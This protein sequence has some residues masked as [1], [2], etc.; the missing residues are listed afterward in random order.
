MRLTKTLQ[1]LI[2]RAERKGQAVKRVR[3][4]SVMGGYCYDAEYIKSTP[5]ID[6]WR[7]TITNTEQDGM[8]FKNVIVDHYGTEICHIVINHTTGERKLHNWYGQS[9]TDRDALN[10]LMD[11]YGL[12]HGFRYRPSTDKFELVS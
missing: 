4:G 9:N 12:S 5:M 11:Y 3:E 10:G 8:R 7:V 6:Q 2:E 1:T